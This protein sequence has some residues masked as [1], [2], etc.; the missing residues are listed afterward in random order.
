MLLE[1]KAVTNLRRLCLRIV[2]RSR[3]KLAGV[4]ISL[5]ATNLQHALVYAVK[6]KVTQ[7]ENNKAVKHCNQKS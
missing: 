2:G 5:P 6:F 7:V 1:K 4:A 3:L